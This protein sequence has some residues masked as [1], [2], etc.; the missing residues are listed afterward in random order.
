MLAVLWV[1]WGQM[2]A[3]DSIWVERVVLRTPLPSVPL[4]SCVQPQ[5]WYAPEHL[6][7][8]WQQDSSELLRWIQA[9]GYWFARVHRL[10]DSE[11]SAV[12]YEVEPGEL[13]RIGAVRVR[14]VPESRISLPVEV[15]DRIG[16]QMRGS[17]ASQA[18]L[19]AMLDSIVRVLVCAGYP[20]ARADVGNVHLVGTTAEISAVVWPGEAARVD[21]ILFLGAEQTRWAFLQ[22][23][24]GVSPGEILSDALLQRAQRRLEYLPW[25]EI[26]APA[27]RR[28]LP[29]GR[30]AAAFTVRE[31]AATRF[32]GLIGY[33]PPVRGQG[34]WSGLLEAQLYNL[35]GTGRRLSV[36]WYRTL[37]LQEFSLQYEEPVPPVLLRGRFEIR[38]RDTSYTESL[39]EGGIQWLGQLS[40]RWYAE[41]FGGWH[42]LQ[43]SGVAGV[44]VPS[45]ALFVGVAGSLGA[46]RPWRNPTEGALG[47]VRLLSRW[48]TSG[49][50]LQNRIAMHGDVEGFHRLSAS[51]VLR[52]HGH[53]RLLWGR[54]VG[55]EEFYRL[56]GMQSF[57]GYRE[58]EFWSPRALWG[59][60]EGRWLLGTQEHVALF[61]DQGWIHNL[62]WKAG[63][64]VQW[65][66]HTAV[67]VLQLLL[68][69][70]VGNALRHGVVGVR[71][72]SGGFEN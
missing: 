63:A 33:A 24:V 54:M 39:W 38:Q 61:V 10:W 52:L 49:Q 56:G 14:S 42:R 36:R 30:W 7:Q 45:T 28:Q 2:Y 71:I 5:R 16:E 8:C 69:W 27:E 25:L 13:V 57:R 31:H 47:G 67:G 60:I 3:A 32:E 65:Q 17:A 35:F 23:W 46:L 53:A 40:A 59:G 20:H 37:S 15:L 58:A 48:R 34:G 66:M 18:A 26:V 72:L 44:L 1:G 62:G 4:P 51:V 29:D 50:M 70:G 55:P 22:R 21:T 19:E 12:Q 43:P 41:L 64:G 9:Q 11:Q 68:G 6:R